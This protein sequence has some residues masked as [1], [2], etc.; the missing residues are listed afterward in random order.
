MSY[1]YR[2]SKPGPSRPQPSRDT[3]Q[4]SPA[5]RMSPDTIH[6]NPQSWSLCFEDTFQYYSPIYAQIFQVICS[7]MFIRP[8]CSYT[9]YLLVSDTLTTHLIPLR[10]P[11]FSSVSCGAQITKFLIMQS[12]LPSSQCLFLNSKY[13]RRHIILKEPQTTL[14][15]SLRDQVS[16]PFGPR[17]NRLLH[18]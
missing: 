5:S 17:N 2:G 4:A 12:P 13:S 7:L 11:A 18:A 1:L 6:F 16:H 14:S 10:F 8:K 9:S 15:V 3:Q